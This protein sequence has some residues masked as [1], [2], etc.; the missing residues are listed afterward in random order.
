MDPKTQKVSL[1]RILTWAFFLVVVTVVVATFLKYFYL[2][3][4]YIETQTECDPESE[5]CF[6]YTCDPEEDED[7]PEDE[8]ERSEYYKKIRKKAYAILSCDSNSEECPALTCDPCEDCQETLCNESN[9]L[10]GEE[11]NDPVKYLE[12]NPPE[13]ECEE[14]DEECVAD[15]EECEEGDEECESAKSV[16]D[17]AEENEEVETEADEAE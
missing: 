14:G 11:C 4:F 2:K 3:D 12:E 6:V 13:E 15:E 7:C 8:S 9:V 16:E 1:E 10:E 17:E 5:A